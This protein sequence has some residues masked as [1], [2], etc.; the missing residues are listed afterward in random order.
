MASPVR[1]LPVRLVDVRAAAARIER[2]VVRTPLVP[3]TLCGA[4]ML[5]LKPESLQ[6]TGA[7]KLRGATNALAQMSSAESSAGVV[8]Y[9]SG[10]H[11]QALACAAFRLGVRADIVMPHETPAIK[12]ASTERW[13]ATVHLVAAADRA[14]VCADIAHRT[15][16]Q[17]V[18][19]Y[20]DVRVIAGQGTIGLEILDQHPQVKEVFV[21]VG[22]GGLISGI[23]VAVKEQR[24]D[25]RIVAVE[26]ALA[27]DFA[28]GFALRQRVSWPVARTSQTI[29][30]GVRTTQLGDLTWA[31]ASEL[32]DDAI[33]VTEDEIGAAFRLLATETPV[34]AEPTGAVAVAGFLSDSSR[35]LTDDAVAVVTGGN[36]DPST[37]ARLLNKQN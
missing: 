13:G 31:I 17:I 4:P 15:G 8:T 9:S 12:V 14:T 34:L 30:D 18:P 19:P 28:E 10:N 1:S 6:A 29:A 21:P 3:V 20:D 11:A 32:V 33:T 16:A 7:F 35:R 23:A 27:G 22:G 24:P 36:V 37:F 2:F 25:V 5:M 26:P